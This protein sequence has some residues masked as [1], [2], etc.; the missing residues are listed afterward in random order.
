MKYIVDE[1]EWQ[2]L[3]I[4]HKD[5]ATNGSESDAWLIMENIHSR[6]YQSER[7][8]VLDEVLLRINN[9]LNGLYDEKKKSFWFR[10]S[11]AKSN[12]IAEFTL[13]FVAGMVEELR[14]KAGEP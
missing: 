14:Q 10:L 8:T 6:P 13:R 5:L 12:S 4:I 3:K 9:L 2:S 7:D 1:E 11:Q